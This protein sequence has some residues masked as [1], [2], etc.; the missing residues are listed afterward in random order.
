MVKL[1]NELINKDPQINKCVGTNSV[2]SPINVFVFVYKG[3]YM[4]V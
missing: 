1:N 4:C 2:L 3:V